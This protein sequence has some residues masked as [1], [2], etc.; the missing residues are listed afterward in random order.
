MSCLPKHGKLEST[1]KESK[2]RVKYGKNKQE[3]GL[4]ENVVFLWLLCKIILWGFMRHYYIK[5]HC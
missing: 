5:E 1:D 2:L 3:T 4:Q